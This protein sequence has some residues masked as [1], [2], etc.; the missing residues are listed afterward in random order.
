MAEYS[1]GDPVWDRPRGDGGPVSLMILGVSE[2][3]VQRMRAWNETY[4]RSAH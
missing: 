3:L 4:E 2:S 1:V